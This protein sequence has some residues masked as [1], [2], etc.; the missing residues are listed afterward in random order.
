MSN[1]RLSMS[2]RAIRIT[3]DLALVAVMSV[4]AISLLMSGAGGATAFNAGVSDTAAIHI[5]A[6]YTE[7]CSNGIAVLFPERNPGLVKD[8]ATLLAV[9]STIEGESGNLN[10]SADVGISRWDAITKIGK[11]HGD[12]AYRVLRLDFS[13]SGTERQWTG[14][15]DL[16]GTIPPELGSL[17]DLEELSIGTNNDLTGTIPPELGNLAN[18]KGLNLGSNHLTGAIPPDL[19]NLGQLYHLQLNRNQL[20][21][22]IPPELG[23]LDNLERLFLFHN[24]LTGAIPPELGN[25]D[26]LEDL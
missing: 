21:G 5:P 18:L 24:Q 16:T 1:S 13:Y 19:G 3:T 25:L 4:I 6:Q 10:W 7:Q 23:S 14:D 2:K 15:F 26:N 8:C 17:D 20:T 12:S 11:L 9:K 22:A